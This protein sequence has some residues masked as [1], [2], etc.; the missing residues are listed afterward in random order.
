MDE[1]AI[2]QAIVD[3]LRSMGLWPDTSGAPK[4]AIE[5]DEGQVSMDTY[6]A[7]FDLEGNKD[8]LPILHAALDHI[9]SQIIDAKSD[10]LSAVG[11][12]AQVL[13]P[14]TWWIEPPTPPTPPP[15]GD[16]AE[17]VWSYPGGESITVYENLQQIQR[18]ADNLDFNVGFPLQGNSLFII[19]GPWTLQ[20]DS[21]QHDRVPTPDW[22]GLVLGETLLAW[23]VRTDPDQTWTADETTGEPVSPA[24]HP[25]NSWTQFRIRPAF[26]SAQFSAM[27]PP[28][29]VPPLDPPTAP[30]WPGIANVMLGTQ[31]TLTDGNVIDEPMDGIVV[32][33]TSHP[34]HAGQYGFG[35]TVS[36]AHVGAVIFRSDNGEW[37]SAQQIAVEQHVLCPKAMRSA[38]SAT[39]RVNGGYGGTVTPWTKTL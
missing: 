31:T 22:G 35:E 27:I 9:S 23:L 25:P 8:S 36:Y 12:P 16:I 24:M 3:I 7:R 33:I 1:L 6:K 39:L 20:P 37:E 34:D 32:N 21:P 26:S 28:A 18:L 4:P 17:A 5:Y 2:A 11:S 30:V 29:P 13:D 38:A 10:I 15:V 14:P 19:D